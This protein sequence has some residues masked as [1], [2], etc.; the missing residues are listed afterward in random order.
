[1][2]KNF[3]GPLVLPR[4][5][6]VFGNETFHRV[7]NPGKKEEKIKSNKLEENFLNTKQ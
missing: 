2:M 1:M 7:E 6:N 5:K 4:G 3:I